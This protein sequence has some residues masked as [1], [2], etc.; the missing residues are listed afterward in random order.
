MPGQTTVHPTSKDC[1][2]LID[3][4]VFK[5]QP[6]NNDQN[7]DIVVLVNQGYVVG[8]SPDRLQP[9]WAA[10][11]VA[12][13]D[14]D[15]DYDRPHLYYDDHRLDPAQRIG[16]KPFGSHDNIQY[17]VGHMVPNEV[18]NRQFGRLAQMETFFMSNMCPQ[19]GSLNT[20]TW[21]KLE[22]AIANIQDVPRQRDHVWAV[23]GP[24]F[25]D[26]PDVLTRSDGKQVPIPEAFFCITFDPF[27]YPWDRLSNVAIAAFLIP[28]DAPGGSDPTDYLSDIEE[29]ERRTRLSF[30]PGWD[31]LPTRSASARDAARSRGGAPEPRNRLLAALAVSGD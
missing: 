5:G 14:Q 8:F 4:F 15:V 25:G 29:I 7:R 27:R 19:R 24:V 21:M 3:L 23:V 31:A 6:V 9:V 1:E 20:G 22:N 2:H 13:F 11:R 16:A 26:A 10:Y 28:Q 30:L 17:H 18:I 12:G